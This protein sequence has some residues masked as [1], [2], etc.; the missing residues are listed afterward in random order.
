[1]TTIYTTDAKATGRRVIRMEAEALAE[2][3]RRIGDGFTVA[4][5]LIAASKGR[6]IV[7]G[8][9]KVRAR[10]AKDCCDAHVHGNPSLISSSGRRPAR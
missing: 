6:V 4:V 5:D 3:E 10:R 1:M 8:V 7:S 2:V 9:G